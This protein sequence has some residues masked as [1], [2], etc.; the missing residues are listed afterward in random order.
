MERP[1][2]TDSKEFAIIRQMYFEPA[3]VKMRDV[4]QE[5]LDNRWVARR[6]NN[7]NNAR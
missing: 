2:L 7:N 6:K 4:D 5:E 1:K 3:E